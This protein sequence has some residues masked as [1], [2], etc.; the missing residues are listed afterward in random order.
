MWFGPILMLSLLLWCHS[1]CAAQPQSSEGISG[2]PAMQNREPTAPDSAQV[3]NPSGL[4]P[5][6]RAEAIAYSQALYRYSLPE[7]GWTVAVLLL[8]LRLKVAPRFRDWAE[9]LARDRFAQALIFVP[10]FL[11]SFDALLLPVDALGQWVQRRFDQSLQGW[12]S[13]LWDHAKSDLLAAVAGVFLV[14]LVSAII[15]RSPRH[16]WFYGWLGAVPVLVFSSFLNPVLIDPLFYRYTPLADSH[17]DL[18][19]QIELVVAR[20]GQWIPEDRIFLMNASQTTKALNAY[21]TGLGASLRVVIWDTTL[22]RMTSSEILYVF[23]HELGHYVLGHRIQSTVFSMAMLLLCSWAGFHAFHWML[24][25][26]GTA[27]ELRAVDD[28]AA[29]P[30]AFLLLYLLNTAS[31]PAQ[32]AFERHLE[33]EADQYGLEIVHGIVP[34]SSQSAVAALQILGDVDLSDPAPSPLVKAWFYNH[35]P[36]EE[37]I[38]FAYDYNPWVPGRTPRFVK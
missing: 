33:H 17:P 28:W 4:S 6:R 7:F 9:A 14:W 23:G 37:R 31:A 13:W 32:N 5:E 2:V 38:R 29:L 3:S 11:L 26:Y 36:L 15:R 21:V 22:A 8:M 30:L 20:S 24:R 18:A 1:I 25:R 35:P 16:W 27:W 19:K 34:N 12:G 10:A